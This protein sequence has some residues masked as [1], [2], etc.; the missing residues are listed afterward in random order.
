MPWAF[1][2]QWRDGCHRNH[3]QSPE[4][5]AERGGLAP[6]EIVALSA[7]DSA[8]RRRLWYAPPEES[9]PRLLE[10]LAVWNTGPEVLARP[11]DR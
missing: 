1:I 7:V 10:M 5:L 4:R 8:E 3:D 11:G 6:E 9:V 2:E